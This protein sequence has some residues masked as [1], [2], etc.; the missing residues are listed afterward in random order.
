[1]RTLRAGAKRRGKKTLQE[2][3][4]GEV[5]ALS[6]KPLLPWLRQGTKV[7]RSSAVGFVSFNPGGIK[8]RG[9]TVEPRPQ[10]AEKLFF[11]KSIR[12]CGVV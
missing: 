11:L 1:M 10:S 6:T 8:L 4:N 12:L 9:T 5:A 7:Q 3:G 2:E